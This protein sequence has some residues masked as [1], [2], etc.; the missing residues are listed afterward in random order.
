MLAYITVSAAV[1]SAQASLSGSLM[2]DD[3]F[4]AYI[5]TSGI[6]P[7]QQIVP[8]N[9]R[10]TTYEFGHVGLTAGPDQWLHVTGVDDGVISA[11]MGSFQFTGSGFARLGGLSAPRGAPSGGR[12]DAVAVC[13]VV[14][15]RRRVHA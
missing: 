3:L 5:G 15:K 7:G 1:A 14:P 10:R 11:F 4:R 8:G 12:L 2:A 9:N 13:S 6:L